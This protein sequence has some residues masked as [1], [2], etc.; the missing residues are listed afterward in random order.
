MEAECPLHRNTC[1]A[2][3]LKCPLIVAG[4]GAVAENPDTIIEIMGR[5]MEV[6]IAG[7]IEGAEGDIPGSYAAQDT[8]VGYTL[9]GSDLIAMEE[10]N[11]KAIDVDELIE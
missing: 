9:I 2:K 10:E 8:V 7:H 4:E 11:L 6:A 3:L 1:L 5:V